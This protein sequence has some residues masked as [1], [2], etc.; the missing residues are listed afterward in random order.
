MEPSAAACA[1]AKRQNGRSGA[2][3]GNRIPPLAYRNAVSGERCASATAT[4]AV[5]GVPGAVPSQGVAVQATSSPRATRLLIRARP[6]SPV[7]PSTRILSLASAVPPL[8][9]S[10][11][12][13]TEWP[14]DRPFYAP[15]G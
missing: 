6:I 12:L 9:V 11:W 10:A 3:P 13:E 7:P 4:R 5:R 2:G 15:R 1:T 8:A 14:F